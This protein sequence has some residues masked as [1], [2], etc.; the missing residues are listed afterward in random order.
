MGVKRFDYVSE[1]YFNTSHSEMV[2]DPTGEYVLFVDYQ[3]LLDMWNRAITE[4]G[5]LKRAVHA[6]KHEWGT[7]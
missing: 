2:E 6:A 7:D 3:A 1:D 5:D 4:T